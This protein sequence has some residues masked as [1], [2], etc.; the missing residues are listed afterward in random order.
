MPYNIEHIQNLPLLEQKI[1]FNEILHKAT[2]GQK[3]ALYT[4]DQLYERGLIVEENKKIAIEYYQKAV[5][6]NHCPSTQA[7]LKLLSINVLY[8]TTGAKIKG[9]IC[10]IYPLHFK[11]REWVS[12]TN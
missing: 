7:L 3:E 5:N 8:P 6:K 11:M 12:V 2:E 1:I 10:N 4:I 9:K